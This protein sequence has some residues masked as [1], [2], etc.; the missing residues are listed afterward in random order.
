MSLAPFRSSA[1]SPNIEHVAKPPGDT[2]ENG[3]YNSFGKFI[4]RRLE[5]T[6]CVQDTVLGGRGYNSEQLT[7]HPDPSWPGRVAG[8]SSRRGHLPCVTCVFMPAFQN[9][10]ISE[11]GFL[12]QKSTQKRN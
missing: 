1:N 4:P 6:C 5:G 7:Q 12:L 9:N 10:N 2:R 3:K 8:R 11:E